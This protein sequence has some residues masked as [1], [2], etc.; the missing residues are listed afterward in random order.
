MWAFGSPFVR[1]R[2]VWA[3]NRPQWKAAPEKSGD[4][5]THL[6]IGDLA[7]QLERA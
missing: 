5:Q 2:L 1:N 7:K 6:I 3:S 4:G